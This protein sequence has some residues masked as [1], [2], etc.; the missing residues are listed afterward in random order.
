MW[1]FILGLILGV[2]AK[3]VYDLFREEQLPTGMGLNTGRLEG[4][5]E[6]TRQGVRDLR[7]ELR[8]AIESGRGT[9]QE[10][11]GRLVGAA[12]EAARGKPGAEGGSQASAAGG[13]TGG[14]AGERLTVTGTDTGGST[15]GSAESSG[16]A[17]GKPSAPTS[18]HGTAETMS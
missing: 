1:T 14:A 9:L 11:A 12:S 4:L 15:S 5:V 2:T 3:A 7:D 10:R 8:Q 6:E 17:S 18:T 13:E 16:S